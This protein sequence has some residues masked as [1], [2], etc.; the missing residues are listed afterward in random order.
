VTCGYQQIEKGPL[1]TTTSAEE[2]LT[3][4][5][6]GILQSPL[7][8]R[9]WVIQERL[10]FP[11]ILHFGENQLFWECS[12]REAWETF[13]DGTPTNAQSFGD[14]MKYKAKYPYGM[15]TRKAPRPT[16]WDPNYLGI[17]NSIISASS[18]SQLT[19]STDK[20]VA[21]SGIARDMQRFIGNAYLGGLWA[22][23][24]V[25]QL[26]WRPKTSA[27]G[28]EDVY[29]A[30]SWSWASLNYKRGVCRPFHRRITSSTRAG[31]DCAKQCQKL[32]EQTK[33]DKSQQVL[34]ESEDI[35]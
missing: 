26:L 1:E 24:M 6:K 33:W 2:W 23:H 16:S 4:V 12:E 19:R 31:R 8:Q 15:L 30:P 32:L 18:A 17:W 27:S 34:F 7:N 3:C 21:I 22:K 13:P 25:Q 10:L 5:G 14:S 11:R 29:Q 9:V 35:Y 28:F 20:L